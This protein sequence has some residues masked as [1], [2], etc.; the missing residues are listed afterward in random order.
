[1]A[2]APCINKH[3]SPWSHLVILFYFICGL[4][5]EKMEGEEGGEGV[6]VSTD[7]NRSIWAKLSTIITDFSP[8]VFFF[9]FFFLRFFIWQSYFFF[10]AFCRC[11]ELETIEEKKSSFCTNFGAFGLWRQQL[12][13]GLVEKVKRVPAPVHYIF[14]ILPLVMIVGE[15]KPDIWHKLVNILRQFFC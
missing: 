2:I 1:M 5:G 13:L 12:G 14:V 7:R 15:M 11:F 4:R 8:S 6:C 3:G 10:F 9:F